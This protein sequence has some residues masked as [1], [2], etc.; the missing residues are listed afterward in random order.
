MSQSIA[1][2]AGMVTIGSPPR[3]PGCLEEAL[4]RPPPPDRRWRPPS[5]R[6]SPV[7]PSRL[8]ATA[9]VERRIRRRPAASPAE[10]FQAITQRGRLAWQ[11]HLLPTR[12]K[13]D[14]PS[15]SDWPRSLVSD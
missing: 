14:P 5:D 3:E 13:T 8:P 4:L 1:P 15:L 11:R 6:A 9:L 12:E 7:P 10:P 2:G